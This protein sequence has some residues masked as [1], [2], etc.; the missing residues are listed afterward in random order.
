MHCAIFDTSLVYC[1]SRDLCSIEEG[2]GIVVYM[3]L[4]WCNG[5][6]DIYVQLKEGRGHSAMGICALCYI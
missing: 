5:F 1:F 4:I 2:G 3:N 6:P